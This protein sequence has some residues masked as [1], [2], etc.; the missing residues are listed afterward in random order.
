M[1]DNINFVPPGTL[2]LTF[3]GKL[4]IRSTVRKLVKQPSL[5]AVQSGSFKINFAL[6]RHESRLKRYSNPANLLDVVE[7]TSLTTNVEILGCKAGLI[8]LRWEMTV[9]NSGSQKVVRGPL[10]VRKAR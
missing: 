4:Q 1:Q 2:V 5:S 7:C 3:R 9:R 8:G 6:A 10:G